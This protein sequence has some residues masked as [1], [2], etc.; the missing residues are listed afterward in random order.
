MKLCIE[1]E[2]YR[3]QYLTDYFFVNFMITETKRKA[4]LQI[5]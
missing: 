3:P 4:T 5:L 1:E 2:D